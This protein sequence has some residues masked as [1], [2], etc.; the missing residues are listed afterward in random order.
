MSAAHEYAAAA[1]MPK[2]ILPRTYLSGYATSE[3]RQRR[4][5]KTNAMSPSHL[6]A[7]PDIRPCAPNVLCES[8]MVD[9]AQLVRSRIMY[10]PRSGSWE[11]L[12]EPLAEE[13]LR[14]RR[15]GSLSSARAVS[16]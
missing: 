6:I 3:L 5:H 13:D 4:A 1:G 11:R 7:I 10:R 9:A 14:D 15:L 2:I 12:V 8:G 16:R